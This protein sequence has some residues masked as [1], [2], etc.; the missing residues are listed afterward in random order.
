MV[1]AKKLHTLRFRDPFRSRLS[2]PATEPPDPR[3]V[4]EEFLKGFLKESLKGFR[5]VLEGVSRGPF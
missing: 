2:F 3:R 1:L 4:P 5:R